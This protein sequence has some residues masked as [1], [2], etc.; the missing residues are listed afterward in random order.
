[1][2]VAPFLDVSEKGLTSR[3][4]SMNCALKIFRAQTNC[5]A[6]NG[7]SS[8]QNLKNVLEKYVISYGEAV[9]GRF[10]KLESI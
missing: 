5:H 2:Y 4:E 8:T 10:S 7:Q 1:M 3:L 9:W 6:R